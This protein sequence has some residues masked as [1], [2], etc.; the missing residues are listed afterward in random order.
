VLG[1]FRR[2]PDS[3]EDVSIGDAF[4]IDPATGS[5]ISGSLVERVDVATSNKAIP[6]VIERGGRMKFTATVIGVYPPEI[7]WSVTG[8]VSTGTAIDP[9]GVL[10]VASDETAASLTITAVSSTDETKSGSLAVAVP[11]PVEGKPA[12]F[13]SADGNDANDGRTPET[14]VLTTDK[15]LELINGG[16][17][18]NKANG[19]AWPTADG[20]NLGILILVKGNVTGATGAAHGTLDFYG[21]GVYYPPIEIRGFDSSHPGTITAAAGKRVLYLN[22]ATVTLGPDLTLTGG[23]VPD[24]DTTNTYYGGG[25]YVGPYSTLTLDSAVITGNTASGGGGVYINGYSASVTMLSG[26]ISNNTTTANANAAGGGVYLDSNGTFIMTGG[27]IAGNT[28]YN[29]ST[30]TTNALGGAGVYVT[31]NI[32]TTEF[33]LGSGAVIDPDNEV[34]LAYYGKVTPMGNSVITLAGDYSGTGTIARIDLASD[35]GFPIDKLYTSWGEKAVLKWADGSQ[36]NYP[37]ERFTLDSFKTGTS[38]ISIGG[39]ASESFSIDPGT[40]IL[41]PK[42]PVAKEVSVSTMSASVVSVERGGKVKFKATVTGFFPPQDV[43]WSVGGNTG[44]GTA[45]DQEGV[46]SVDPNETAA[47]LTVTAASILDQNVTGSAS[48]KVPAPVDGKLT[49]FISANGADTDDGRT[50][51]TPVLTTT[52][53]LS[54]IRASYDTN[55]KN[56]GAWPQGE[57][58]DLE[59]LIVV[60]G[61]ITGSGGCSSTGGGLINL[62]NSYYPSLYIRGASSE[63]PG[64]LH[65]NY[66]TS[67]SMSARVLNVGTGNKVTLGSDLTLKGGVLRTYTGGGIAVSGSLVIDGATI[68]GNESIN[69]SSNDGGQGTAIIVSGT[70]I[71]KSGSITGNKN[72]KSPPSSYDF[73]HPVA[74]FVNR[75]EFRMEGGEISNNTSTS[76]GAGVGV[77]DGG[78]FIMTGG[79]I[80]GN[81]AGYDGEGTLIADSNKVGGGVLLKGGGTFDFQGGSITGNSTSL[82]LGQGVYIHGSS[83][84]SYTYHNPSTFKLGKD[85]VLG[86]ND[87]ILVSNTIPS[88]SSVEVGSVAVGS[89]TVVLANDFASTGDPLTK[90]S[91]VGQKTAADNAYITEWADPQRQILK[92]ESS[93][94]SLPLNRFTWGSL[95]S[96]DFI[97]NIPNGTGPGTWRVDAS[98]GI[99]SA[100]VPAEGGGGE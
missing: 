85:A 46:L 4:L 33:R 63:S 70:A 12:W 84:T 95:F 9:D 97:A 90:I 19:G 44:S 54:L 6:P 55:N 75:G 59:A 58:G 28:V 77:A 98:T 24:S 35:A 79:T 16:Y 15:V 76:H 42:T 34:R 39:L 43:T 32:R 45:I 64:T 29:T 36:G 86:S 65:V 78:V 18:L 50:P 26:S 38:S 89:N 73:I 92:W 49:W 62:D 93:T 57:G 53:L 56:G 100:T 71:F 83:N 1:K 5:L 74:V 80:T 11:A 31:P 2:G 40:G 10:S 8:N 52:K 91:I 14:P 96:K 13:V 60:E 21:N 69:Y 17:L 61:I 88:S 7:T 72:T 30:S 37:V 81:K 94:A 99:V 22:Y 3:D 68:T 67:A 82:G 25:V 23:S 48:I 27:T 87:D 66:P 20:E 51:E 47:S 41:K